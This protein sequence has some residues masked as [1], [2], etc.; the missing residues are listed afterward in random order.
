MQDMVSVRRGAAGLVSGASSA[1]Q[2]QVAGVEARLDKVVQTLERKALGG[3]TYNIPAG[4]N[5]EATARAVALRLRS[6]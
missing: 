5:P 4:A 3:D 2:L 1:V 6:S